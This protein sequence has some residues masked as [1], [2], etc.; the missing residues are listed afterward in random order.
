MVTGN[1]TSL[2]SFE[3]WMR[4]RLKFN[5]LSL[6]TCMSLDFGRWALG[7]YSQS[8]LLATWNNYRS[9]NRSFK[10]IQMEKQLKCTHQKKKCHLL[11]MSGYISFTKT[12]VLFMLIGIDYWS[13]NFTDSLFPFECGNR[14]SNRARKINH[15]LNTEQSVG[16][17]FDAGPIANI[18]RSKNTH[19]NMNEKCEKL[20]CN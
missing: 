8:Q 13:I 10:L 17:D 2:Q 12:Q 7:S 16:I 11:W 6:A 9:M 4:S 18:A 15:H 14:H 1:R 19:L 3:C 5:N 20:N